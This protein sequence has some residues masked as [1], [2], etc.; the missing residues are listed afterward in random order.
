MNDVLTYKFILIGASGVGKSSILKR[1]V[2]DDFI[3][4]TA[5][6]IG[7]EFD[8]TTITLEGQP[9]KLQIWDTAGQE[10]FRSI[11]KAYYRNAV[12]VLLVFDLTERKSF[13]YLTSWLNDVRALCD[14]N[15]IVQLIGN[16]SDC[17][18]PRVVSLNEAEEFAREFHLDY[19]ETSA[20]AGKNIK[21]AFTGIASKLLARGLKTQGPI[22]PPPVGRT[23]GTTTPSSGCC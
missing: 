11:T 6:T 13:D 3:E 20:K 14:P 12:G 18:H 2:E 15:V 22:A 4:D 10:R 5:S 23:M 19:L 9:V 16:K 17:P 1:M 21:E 7:V 8:S